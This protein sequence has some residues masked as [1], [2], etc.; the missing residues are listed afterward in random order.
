MDVRRLMV[1]LKLCPFE[2]GDEVAGLNP[3]LFQGQ[4]QQQIPRGNDRKKGKSKGFLRTRDLALESLSSDPW[5]RVLA[6]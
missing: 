2:L 1:R 4:E 6:F 5:C 3:D